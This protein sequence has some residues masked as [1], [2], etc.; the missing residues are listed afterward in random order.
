MTKLLVALAAALGAGGGDITVPVVERHLTALQRIADESGGTRVAGSAGDRRT[1]DYV[2][3]ELRRLGWRVRIQSLRVPLH[4]VRGRPRV[5]S[6]REGT[7]FAVQQ[8]SPGFRGTL[9]PRPFD[10]LGCEAAE[11]GTLTRADLA[12]VRRGTCRFRRKL[13]AAQEAGAGGIAVVDDDGAE[14]TRATLLTPRGLRIPAIA[15]TGAAAARLARSGEPVDVAIDATSEVR[16]TRNVIADGGGDGPVVM[17][18]AHL[19]SVAAGPGINDDGSGIA[20]LLAIAERERGTS[21]RL[22]FWAA[23]EVGLDGSRRYVG[24]LPEPEREAIRAYVNLDMVGSPNA[25]VEVYDTGNRVE[26]A[27][28]DALGGDVEQ[29]RVGAVAD[30][31]PFE[32]AGIPV[33]GIYTGGD[34]PGPGGRDR[35]RCYH[36]ACDTRGH[37]DARLA[38]RMA[39]AADEAL[40]ALAR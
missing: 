32:E 17:A 29:S 4:A 37:A 33:G 22:G 8:F 14:P 40:E 28:R 9:R 12:M 20:A 35:D 15:L 10:T 23:E 26:R 2:A 25:V 3:G 38:T 13:L 16:T 27:L 19:D 18:G 6:L 7:D 21:I 31:W 36:R 11:L 1:A 24:S 5:G 34:E 39:R 30:H